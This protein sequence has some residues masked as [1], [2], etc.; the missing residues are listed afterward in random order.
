MAYIIIW[1]LIAFCVPCFHLPFASKGYATR[2]KPEALH[3]PV[4]LMTIFN[5]WISDFMSNWHLTAPPPV[6]LPI[7]LKCSRFGCFLIGLVGGQIRVA[8]TKM[9][10]NE[11]PL[12]RAA[13]RFPCT[14][15]VLSVDHSAP[16]AGEAAVAAVTAVAAAAAAVAGMPAGNYNN[17]ISI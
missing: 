10:Y 15:A 8:T 3:S 1:C 2:A 12:N 9:N 13:L 11:P 4:P 16:A 6:F 5:Y 17:S 7:W 14:I